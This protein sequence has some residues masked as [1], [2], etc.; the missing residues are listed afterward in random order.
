MERLVG[1]GR[2]GRGGVRCRARGMG[3]VKRMRWRLE[4]RLA[5]AILL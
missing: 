4:K 1:E 5:G 3:S 2:V